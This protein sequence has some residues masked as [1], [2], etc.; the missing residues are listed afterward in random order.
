MALLSCHLIYGLQAASAIG[1]FG[2]LVSMALGL[3]KHAGGII[4]VGGL[5]L[6]C[7]LLAY[8]TR[9]LV[10]RAG[11]SFGMPWL[12]VHLKYQGSTFWIAFALFLPIFFF[13]GIALLLSALAILYRS[14]YGWFMLAKHQKLVQKSR[15]QT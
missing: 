2:E 4:L 1:F 10:H 9:Y 13:M 8:A 11:L 14:V 12:V 6:F 5:M 7:L 3:R 15:Q